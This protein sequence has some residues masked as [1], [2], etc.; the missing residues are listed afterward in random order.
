GMI[1]TLIGALAALAQYDIKKILAYSTMSQLGLM[2]L[3]LGM[4]VV[5]AAFLHLLT[6]AFFK[7]C[8]FLTAGMVIHSLSS[9]AD[10][11]AQD[12]RNMGGLKQQMPVAFAAFLLGGASLAGI[13][14]FS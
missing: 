5:D 6:H 12:V 13:P 4:G 3:A 2:V 1:T 11:D 8:L 9:E 7:A 14:L 10:F